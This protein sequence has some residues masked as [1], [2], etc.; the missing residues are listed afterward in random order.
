MKNKNETLA[1]L[2]SKFRNN[3]FFRML[4]AP[5]VIVN[6]KLN[7]LLYRFTKDSKKVKTLHNAFEGKRC[8]IIGNGPSLTVDDLEKIKDEYSL[9]SNRIYKI[10]SKT[11]WRPTFYFCADLDVLTAEIDN[12]RKLDIKYK[13]IRKT[14]KRWKVKE[15]DNIC[16]FIEYGAYYIHRSHFEKIGISTDCSKYISTST[17]VTCNMIEF[18]IYLGFKEI[19]LLG[20]DASFPIAIY[21]DGTVVID[22]SIKSHFDGADGKISEKTVIKNYKNYSYPEATNQCYQ[23]YKEYAE[24][25]DISIVNCTRGGRLEIYERK[26]L[27]DVL[28]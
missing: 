26:C 13:F 2:K 9:A 14:F 25:K 28:T 6:S 21:R 15:T 16:Q 10:F 23:I 27:E 8:F 7:L 1:E 22:E 20:I 17:T 19:Y 12:I 5:L 11:K 18:A 24:A 3:N 4:C